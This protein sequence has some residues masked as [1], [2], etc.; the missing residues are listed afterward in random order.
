MR[1]SK[2]SNPLVEEITNL[3]ALGVE[4]AHL[5][6]KSHIEKLLLMNALLG[7]K[8]FTQE[9]DPHFPLTPTSHNTTLSTPEDDSLGTFVKKIGFNCHTVSALGHRLG[10]EL[11]LCRRV[12]A[13]KRERG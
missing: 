1:G 11:L 8:N 13:D 7:N 6:V 5:R 2:K 3:L 4:L 12:A 10:D 9:P